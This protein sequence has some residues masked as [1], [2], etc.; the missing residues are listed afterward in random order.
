MENLYHYG[1]IAQETAANTD[2]FGCSLA[3]VNLPRGEIL[4]RQLKTD[5]DQSYYLYIPFNAGSS[6]KLFVSVHGISRNAGEHARYFTGL[7]ERHGVVVVSPL[8]TKLRF[9]DYQRL[10]HQ[11]RGLRADQMLDRIVDEVGWLTFADNSR[12]YLFGYSGGGQFVHRYAMAHPGRVAGVAIGAAGWYT[13]PDFDC[14][15]PRGTGS[16]R[17][18]PDI[19]FDPDK[20]LRIPACVLVGERDNRTDPSLNQ[21]G[22]INEQQGCNRLQRGRRWIEAM[23]QA[24]RSH[25]LTTPYRFHVLPKAGHSFQRCMLR[26]AM[27]DIASQFLFEPWRP[28][29]LQAKRFSPECTSQL[30]G[31]LSPSHHNAAIFA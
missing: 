11:G 10:G 14:R 12:L 5:P 7:A 21:S 19:G 18:L 2:P 15:Y 8:F 3:A 16:S 22:P 1:R 30:Q 20:F 9:P 23:Q 6:P 13:F 27:G 17:K 28:G 31:M 24:A 26:G 25:G 29:L 4:Q